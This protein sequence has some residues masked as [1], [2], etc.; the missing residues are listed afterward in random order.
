MA[1]NNPVGDNARVGAVRDRSQT[2]NPK[3]GTW[4]KRNTDTGHFMD[5]KAD[6]EPFKGESFLRQGEQLICNFG[7]SVWWIG[8]LLFER[9]EKRSR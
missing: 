9:Q 8:K 6:G 7:Q 5:Q 2:F 4:E 3:T 1:K